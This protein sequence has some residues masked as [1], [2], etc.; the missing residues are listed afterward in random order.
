[1][2]KTIGINT[3]KKEEILDITPRIEEIIQESGVKEGLCSIYSKHTTAS[4]IINENDD[5]CVQEDI[6]KFFSQTVKKG[7]WTHDFSGRCDRDQNGNCHIKAS[8]IGPSET[9]PIK[10]GKLLLG[11]WQS[12]FFCEFDGPRSPREIVVTILGRE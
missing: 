12:I 8:M 4:I 10:D 2:M 1:M 5:P 6:L 11:R 3:T 7:V 9:V